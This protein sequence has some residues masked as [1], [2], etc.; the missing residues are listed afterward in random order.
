MALYGPVQD[1]EG[2][3]WY[4]CIMTDAFMKIVHLKV[5]ADKMAQMVTTCIRQ[6]WCFLYGMPKSIYTDQQIKVWS[7][8]TPFL[9]FSVRFWASTA[10]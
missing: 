8:V 1:P 10:P 6:D 5:L 3:K 4:V 2:A 7:S 9:D